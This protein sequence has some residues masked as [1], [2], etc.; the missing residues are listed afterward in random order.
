MSQANQR[1]ML[2]WTRQ[3]VYV[4]CT[5]CQTVQFSERDGNYWNTQ[6]WLIGV[7]Q[8]WNRVSG[9]LGQQFGSGSG[10]G[11]KPGPGFLTW[12]L[13]QCCCRYHWARRLSHSAQCTL[14]HYTLTL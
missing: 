13:V 14:A 5:Q 1:R 10:H 11:S 3:S 6:L 12:I 7:L 8:R 9:S 2:G 4:R